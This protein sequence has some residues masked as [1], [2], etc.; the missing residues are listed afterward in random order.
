MENFWRIAES[1]DIFISDLGGVCDFRFFAVADL[2]AAADRCASAAGTGRHRPAATIYTGIWNVVF[3]LR[4]LFHKAARAD[5]P[6]NPRWSC[7]DPAGMWHFLDECRRTC[8]YEIMEVVF[9]MSHA[10]FIVSRVDWID[11]V[12]VVRRPDAAEVGMGISGNTG[13]YRITGTGST[14]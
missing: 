6:Q 10:I 11:G 5:L 4:I 13:F 8:K 12:Y 2:P 9:K 14:G 7:C 1:S 3:D